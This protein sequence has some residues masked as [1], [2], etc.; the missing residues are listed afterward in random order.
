MNSVGLLLS[1]LGSLATLGTTGGCGGESALAGGASHLVLTVL[2]QDAVLE[3]DQRID[4][5]CFSTRVFSEDS[6]NGLLHLHAG[7]AFV[8]FGGS[9][10]HVK[11]QLDDVV[12]LVS[13]IQVSKAFGDSGVLASGSL[14]ANGRLRSFVLLRLVVLR[15][16]GR[17]V[18]DP[19]VFILVPDGELLL[20]L[21]LLC[22]N[23][24]VDD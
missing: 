9:L 3:V 18:D 20:L 2:L 14:E 7:N 5:N 17:V 23:E 4:W 19:V 24:V 1:G 16:L 22:R 12:E 13:R 6:L 21:V 11:L 10:G 15:D 8:V